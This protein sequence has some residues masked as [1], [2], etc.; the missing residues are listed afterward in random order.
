MKLENYQSIKSGE[1]DIEGMVCLVGSN[2][3]G[4]TAVLRAIRDFVLNKSPNYIFSKNKINALS[5]EGY[6]EID[7]IT[8]SKKSS[9]GSAVGKDKQLNNIQNVSLIKE[10]DLKN[11]SVLDDDKIQNCLPQFSFHRDG[12]FE[13]FP[14]FL[15]PNQ[16]YGVFHFLYDVDVFVKIQNVMKEKVKENEMEM[17]KKKVMSDVLLRDINNLEAELGEYPQDQV[18]EKLR[19]R[20]E[21][22]MGFIEI[23]QKNNDQLIE[24]KRKKLGLIQESIEMEKTYIKIVEYLNMKEGIEIKQGE[25]IKLLESKKQIDKRN[26]ELSVYSE[27]I[28]SLIKEF[29]SISDL[30]EKI[31]NITSNI[32]ITEKKIGEKNRELNEKGVYI[33]EERK[34]LKDIVSE[35][36]NCPVCGNLITDINKF[37]VGYE[38]FM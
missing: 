8:L 24:S 26:K 21:A 37:I 12:K 36:D 19:D 28:K 30:I 2:N 34:K 4:K 13:L 22:I 29:D 6:I 16:L 1:I 9:S 15:S 17:N 18:V 23:T 38:K 14:F 7:G 32:E 31:E 27:E 25:K 3:S 10:F 20:Y 35:I 11:F 33:L 5:K